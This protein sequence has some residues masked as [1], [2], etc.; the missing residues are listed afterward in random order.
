MTVRDWSDTTNA[1]LQDAWTRIVNYLPNLIGAIVIIVIGVLVANIIKWIIARLVDASR[2]QSAFDSLSFTQALKRAKVSTDLPEMIGQFAK[3]L[4]IVL[5]LLPAASILGLS[6]I[7][8]I[9]NNIILYLPN[10]GSAV[11][12][13]FL[14]AL[15]ATF[16]GNIVRAT[17]AG[18]GADM[19]GGL[20]T[21]SRYL[22]LIFAGLTAL[23]QL[24]IALPVINILLT[25]FVAAAAIAIGLAFGLG[26]KDA[27]ADL[28]AK[29]RRD[30]SQ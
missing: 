10:I 17:A 30:F 18:L 28:V 2:L 19:S 24:G 5:F 14:G 4:T 7:S 29:I 27:A 25:G 22:I 1:A 16:I 8:N 13:I 23:S 26:G 20:A 3:W 9:L 15:F 11:I 12:I 21:L 6:Q